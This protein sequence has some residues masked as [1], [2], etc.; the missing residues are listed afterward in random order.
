MMTNCSYKDNNFNLTMQ[1]GDH[2]MSMLFVGDDR[3]FRLSGDLLKGSGD[4]GDID[5]IVYKSGDITINFV[6]SFASD[7]LVF[8]NAGR[9]C[10]DYFLVFMLDKADATKSIIDLSA[11]VLR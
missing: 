7:A 9:K 1:D 2:W 8:G 5:K 10:F 3:Q 11:D 6:S 4:Y